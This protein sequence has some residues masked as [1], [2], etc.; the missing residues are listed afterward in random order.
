MFVELDA[1]VPLCGV[2]FRLQTVAGDD[3]SI[4]SVMWWQ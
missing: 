1:N 4:R 3:D 2:W